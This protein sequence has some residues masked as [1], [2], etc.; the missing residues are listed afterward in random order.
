MRPRHLLAVALACIACLLPASACAAVYR[1]GLGTE[2]ATLVAGL[3]DPILIDAGNADGYAIEASGTVKAWGSAKDG[4][5][6]DGTKA[7]SEAAVTVHLPAGVKAVSL[8][9]AERSGFAVTSTGEVY[10]WGDDKNG[11]LCQGTQVA[12]VKTPQ[13]IAGLSGV[14][15]AQG[16][17]HS[18]LF[19]LANGTVDACGW[20]D[21]GQIGLSGVSEA[22]V[23]MPVPGLSHIVELSVGPRV[24]AVLTAAGEV[25]MSGTNQAG[26]LG[27]GYGVGRE[28]TFTLVPLPGRASSVSVGG[29][30]PDSHTLALVAGVPYGWGVDEGGEIGDGSTTSKYTP[31]VAS[32]LTT[33]D[34]TALKAS[35]HSSIGIAGGEVYS[36][37]ENLSGELGTG[38]GQSFSPELADR[39]AIEISATARNALDRH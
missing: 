5:L 6:G 39:G 28:A 3:N 7:D 32:E 24:S 11:D 19:L 13:R 8:G 12:D 35:G 31:V 15:A 18:V 38:G 23:P 17:K 16:A 14:V 21:V 36:W 1:W 33:H 34:F 4:A 27:L 10:D 26:Q 37:G 20:N 30:S 29:G 25:L 9:E 22:V 2:T